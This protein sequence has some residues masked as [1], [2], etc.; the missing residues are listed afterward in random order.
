[1]EQLQFEPHLL[2]KPKR[3]GLNIETTLRHFAIITYMVEPSELRPLIHDRFQ[4]DCITAEDGSTKALIS[5]VPFLDLD[6]RFAKCPWATWCFGQTNYRAYVLDSETREHCVWF[7][8]TTLDSFTNVVPRYVWKL[9]WH[10]GRIHFDC[11]YSQ[12]AGR[13]TSYRMTTKSRWAPAE[14]EVEDS[15]KPPQRLIGFSS[16]ETGLVLLTHPLRGYFYRRDGLLGSYSVWHDRL[17]PTTGNLIEGQ[18]PLLAH[19][20][21]VSAG[22]LSSVHSVLLQPSTDFTIYLPPLVIQTGTSR[23]GY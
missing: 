10:K 11:E 15:G 3:S 6:F 14:I 1:M 2:A 16:L 12:A 19:L 21:L 5:V 23:A 9:P 4:L 18:F 8:G 20:G 13:Y 17:Q 7:F 22:D